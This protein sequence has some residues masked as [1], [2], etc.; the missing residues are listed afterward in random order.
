MCSALGSRTAPSSRSA[1]GHAAS[2]LAEVCE[3]P[4]ANSVTSWPSAISSS[5]SQDTTLSV[6]PY[7]LGGIASVNGAICAICIDFNLS[8]SR[9]GIAAVPA[10]SDADTTT[11]Q[12]RNISIPAWNLFFAKR[13]TF[14]RPRSEGMKSAVDRH[15]RDEVPT[16]N[17]RKLDMVV[18]RG[19]SQKFLCGRLIHL[20]VPGVVTLC[21]TGVGGGSIRERSF[22]THGR[23]L[24]L[25]H[26]SPC[27]RL[28]L[29][30]AA[31]GVAC[32]HS[33]RG[34]HRRGMLGRH[35]IRREVPGRR[36]VQSQCR[37][38]MDGVPRARRP[39]RCR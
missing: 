38:R 1:R 12:G 21:G 17:G 7:S 25:C 20:R 37:K 18:P 13:G 31:A 19:V 9:Y 14:S 24:R 26:P 22:D 8:W 35:P 15:W 39:D 36:A 2:S 16:Q 29:C 33:R 6:P 11:N 30:P 5:V 28:S 10:M 34:A 27:L 3:S 32:G 4:E 23:S